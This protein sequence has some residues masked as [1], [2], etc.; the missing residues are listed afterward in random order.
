MKRRP[1]PTTSVHTSRRRRTAFTLVEVMISVALALMLIYGI[2]QV[3]KLSGDTVGAN[4]AVATMVRDQRA[5][6][7]TLT[8][9]FRNSLFDSPLFLISNRI[10]Y[11]YNGANTGFKAGWKNAE[12]E[13]DEGV[14]ADPLLPTMINGSTV[15]APSIA[16]GSDRTPRLD[17]LAF[18]MRNLYRRQTSAYAQ[19]SS[20]TTS[21]DAF[22]WY[23][24]TAAPTDTTDAAKPATIEPFEQYAV[25]RILGRTVILLKDSNT[26]YSTAA[27]DPINVPQAS[28]LYPLGWTA[29][30]RDPKKLEIKGNSAPAY[31][32]VKDL[33]PVSLDE[34]RGIAD[35]AYTASPVNWFRPMAD[36]DPGTRQWWRAWCRPTVTRP[37][38]QIKMAQTAPYFVGHCTQFI[39]EYA[40][41]YLY[42]NEA[43]VEVPGV[44]VDV[45]VKMNPKT[46]D[47]VYGQT[48][49]LIDYIIDTS[50]DGTF[51]STGKFKLNDPPKD[52]SK[53]ARRVR[54][55][56]L[57]RDVTGDGRITINDVV[58]LSDV[59]AYY[60]MT[61]AAPG[62][63]TSPASKQRAIAP[64]EVDL[65]NMP[66]P[67]EDNTLVKQGLIDSKL[68]NNALPPHTANPTA[69]GAKYAQQDYGMIDRDLTTGQVDP[70]LSKSKAPAFLYTA[71]FHNDAPAMIRISM[72]IED[73]S[74]KLKDGQWYQFVLSR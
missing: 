64:W 29:P 20:G 49:G 66:Q 74:G 36:P 59:L 28:P 52:P 57:P 73:P 17:R 3:F 67:T 11:G 1:T 16:A 65:P 5:A 69:A 35:A 12:E 44:P 33:A 43:D 60:E 70:S 4:Q 13:R 71:A 51:D 21:T 45:G 23:G 10:A 53:W 48:D 9:D 40:G 50:A 8:E 47:L 6:E 46:G 22:V 37:I 41:D 38:N 15:P 63:T 25:D 68:K 72:K 31:Q 42:Q 62:D 24:H 34:W 32:S 18:F 58:P 39:V 27:E 61:M 56:G 14:N 7:A 19:A 54:W 2:A 55:Y 26:T 30:E